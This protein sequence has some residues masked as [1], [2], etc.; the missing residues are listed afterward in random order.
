[1]KKGFKLFFIFYLLCQTNF[2]YLL[3]KSSI[4]EPLSTVV[5][6]LMLIVY[7]RKINKG[8]YKFNLFI[9]FIIMFLLLNIVFSYLKYGQPFYFVIYAAEYNFLI[10]SY[11]IFMSYMKNGVD[12]KELEKI[13]IYFALVLIILFNIQYLVYDKGLIF[14]SVNFS[15]RFESLRINSTTIIPNLGFLL[16]MINLMNSDNKKDF[17]IICLSE[18][19]LSVIYI[20][21][22]SKVR[23]ALLILVGCIFIYFILENKQKI[24]ILLYI[25]LFLAI[26][27]IPIIYYGQSTT[28]LDKYMSSFSDNDSS[29]SIRM[30]EIK[31]FY[32]Q[33]KENPL[34]GAGVIQ[35]VKD[36]KTYFI[37][38]GNGGE[39]FTND[40]GIF[41][42]L[43]NWG[44]TGVILYIYMMVKILQM[45][46]IINKNKCSRQS[47][48]SY[49]LFAYM[50]FTSVTLI[51]T[52][53]YRNFM[54]PIILVII[55]KQLN[56]S[57]EFNK[58]KKYINEKKEIKKI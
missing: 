51:I 40:V 3:P 39:Y 26:A 10:L 13:Y 58:S 52:D 45:L 41:G 38:R 5:I 31:Y 12:V 18:V 14:L 37:L 22:V 6:I 17:R 9:I 23:S 33:A 44:F 50:I 42:L 25:G 21:F 32:T 35:P 43:Q 54:L 28:I 30:N 47:V 1:M 8:K 56:D 15:F 46:I 24:F 7:Y 49:V 36:T 27:C 16:S 19:I 48:E 11:Y 20:I 55:E 2:L 53:R 34:F 4:Y 57:I 29:Y